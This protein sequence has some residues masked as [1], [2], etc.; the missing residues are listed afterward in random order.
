MIRDQ[1]LLDIA[2]EIIGGKRLPKH[3][4]VRMCGN[5][6]SPPMAAALVQ[7]NVPE[8]GSWSTRERKRLEAA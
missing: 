1:L 7:A 8:M 4:Q 2:P 3:A 6:V 5:S